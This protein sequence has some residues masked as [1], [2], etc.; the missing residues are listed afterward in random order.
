MQDTPIDPEV[1]ST[2]PPEPDTAT[3]LSR[4]EPVEKFGDWIGDAVSGLPEW[5]QPLLLIG[6]GTLVAVLIQVVIYTILNRVSRDTGR[7]QSRRIVECIGLSSLTFAVI[8]GASLGTAV[9]SNRDL[10]GPW[11][12]RVWPQTATVA[13]I[14]SFTAMILGLIRGV[15][16]MLLARY[17]LDVRDN[18]R[19]RRMHTQVAVISRTLRII[20]AIIGVAAALT[21]FESV[22]RFGATFLASAGIAGIAVGFAAKP[23]LENVIAGIQIALT[24]PIRLEDVVIIEGEYG[25]VEEITTTY[26]VIRVWD[27]RRIIVPF[28]KIIDS[29]FENWTRRSSDLMGKVMLYLDYTADIAAIREKLE[30]ITNGHPLWDNRTRSIT[31]V[32]TDDR[33][34]HVRALVSA[35]DASALWDLRCN[36]RERLIDWLRTE[37]PE[38]LPVA[39][40]VQFHNQGAGVTIPRRQGDEA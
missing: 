1:A 20:V 2:G 34:V 25:N 35:G 18:F 31:V 11:I 23:V 32:G 8:L 24:Q 33:T 7:L 4:F 10:L 28:S 14:L 30:E 9:A 13:I 6:A 19:A 17:T 22:E 16:R 3:Q 36:V 15:D 29:P 27:K 12:E 38:W 26:V 5:L 37:H 21:T 39:R 40:E